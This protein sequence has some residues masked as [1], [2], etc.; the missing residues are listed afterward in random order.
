[1]S[2]CLITIADREEYAD[3]RQVKDCGSC[4]YYRNLFASHKFAQCDY[5]NKNMYAKYDGKPEWCTLDYVI[6]VH[7]Q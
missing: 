6:V 1:M 5:Y 7:K 4:P 3:I 2:V